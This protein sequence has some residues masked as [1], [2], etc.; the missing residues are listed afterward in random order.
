MADTI[1]SLN[2]QRGACK[3]KLARISTILDNEELKYSL[4][5]EV[6]LTN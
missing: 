5:F 2:K 6:K 1:A 3:G 4:E